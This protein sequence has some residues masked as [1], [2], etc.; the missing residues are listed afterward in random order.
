MRKCGNKLFLDYRLKHML[1]FDFFEAIKDMFNE[2][3]QKLITF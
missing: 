3:K 2:S 1:E